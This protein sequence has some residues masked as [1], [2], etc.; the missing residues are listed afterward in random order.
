[1]ERF[2]PK[3]IVK[4]VKVAKIVNW[5]EICLFNK[6]QS[7]VISQLVFRKKK[8]RKRKLES[9]HWFRTNITQELPE[10]YLYRNLALIRL[11]KNSLLMVLLKIIKQSCDN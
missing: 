4:T 10:L 6:L 2:K 11:Y 1:M 3:I 5:E 9:P 7:K 8:L